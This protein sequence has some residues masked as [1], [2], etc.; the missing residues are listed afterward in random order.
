MN[1]VI[2]VKRAATGKVETFNLTGNCTQQQYENL[3]KELGLQPDNSS[4]E[5]KE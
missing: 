5:P 1:M 4:N 2:H 3:S